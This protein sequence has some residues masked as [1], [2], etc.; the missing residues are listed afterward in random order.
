MDSSGAKLPIAAALAVVIRNDE[1][2]LV[3]RENPPDEGLWG[4]PGGKIEPGE[5]VANAAVRE[6]REETGVEAIP[7]RVFTAVDVLDDDGAV[8][9]HFVLIAVLCQWVEGEPVACDDATDARWVSLSMLGRNDMP[10]SADVA[11]VARQA[12]QIIKAGTS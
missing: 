7:I 1:V 11:D 3:R 8:F 9:H 12:G 4:F 10:L 2:L 5:K 6:L